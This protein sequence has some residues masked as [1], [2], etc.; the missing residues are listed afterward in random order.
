M[1]RCRGRERQRGPVRL[2]PGCWRTLLVRSEQAQKWKQARAERGSEARGREP[3]L[4]G[5][6]REFRVV[7]LPH[8]PSP[9]LLAFRAS[10]ARSSLLAI[11]SDSNAQPCEVCGVETTSRC[12]SC[13]L[14]GLDLFFCSR[15]HQ[16]LVRLSSLSSKRP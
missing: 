3:T 2:A 9:P 11:P 5:R 16:K 12:L 6:V 7:L 14:A 10:Q 13:Q 1:R 4:P 8:S 15:A